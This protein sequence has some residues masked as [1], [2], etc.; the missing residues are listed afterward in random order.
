MQECVPRSGLPSSFSAKHPN[1]PS[2]NRKLSHNGVRPREHLAYFRDLSCDSHAWTGL[3]WCRHHAG[4]GCRR[5]GSP[6]FRTA[7]C[8]DLRPWG[9]MGVSHSREN[10][11]LTLHCSPACRT[12]RCVSFRLRIRHEWSKRARHGLCGRFPATP[13][14]AEGKDRHGGTFGGSR[15]C[16]WTG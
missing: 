12:D 5:G 16:H 8:G 10:F 13:K 2:E 6:C 1:Q 14:S 9:E 11:G 15:C 3:A 7:S 4:A